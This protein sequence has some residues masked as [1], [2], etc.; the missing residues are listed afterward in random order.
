[1]SDV[2]RRRHFVRE[3]RDKATGDDSCNLGAVSQDHSKDPRYPF[4]VAYQDR[5][6]A[7]RRDVPLCVQNEIELRL[8]PEDWAQ[9]DHGAIDWGN[10]E[11][12]LLR[13][14]ADP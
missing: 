13:D 6:W 4:L 10:L 7:K 1:M 12:E 2:E 14:V 11:I 8:W 3:N 5:L 9:L